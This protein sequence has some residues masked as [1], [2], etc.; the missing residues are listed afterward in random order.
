MLCSPQLPPL[1]LFPLSQIL[2]LVITVTFHSLR[3]RFKFA[4]ETDNKNYLRAAESL[5]ILLK[6]RFIN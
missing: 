5:Q 3:M 4:S 1:M 6:K 2:P